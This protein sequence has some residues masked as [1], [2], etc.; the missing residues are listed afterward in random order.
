MRRTFLLSVDAIRH[1]PAGTSRCNAHRLF[2]TE[3]IDDSPKRPRVLA[4]ESSTNNDDGPFYSKYYKLGQSEVESY[5]KRHDLKYRKTGRHLVVQECP[6]CHPTK[7]AP[8]NMYKLYILASTGVYKCHRCQA[9]GSWF[10]LRKEIGGAFDDFQ[11]LMEMGEFSDSGPEVDLDP[12]KP[13]PPRTSLKEYHNN[14]H[15]KHNDML[16]FIKEQR[17]LTA[18]VLAAYSVGLAHNTFRDE[19]SGEYCQEQCYMFPMFSSRRKL[20]RYKVRAVHKKRFM[21]LE[22]KG[23]DWGLFGFD[24]L[25][26]GTKEVVLTE[27]EFDAMAVYQ[28]TGRPALSLPNG[29]SSLPVSV[30]QALER[31]KTIYLWMDDDIPGQDGAKQFA[32]KLG[33]NRCRVVLTDGRAKDAN[34]ALLK[35]LDLEAMVA[36]AGP[37]PHEGVA[38][39]KD[40]KNEVYNEVMYPNQLKGM[41]S[42]LLPRLT[43]VLSGHRRGELTIYSGHT[44]TG[45]TTLLSQLSLDYCIQ[46]VPTLWGS[47]EIR[48][49]RLARLLLEQLYSSQTKQ[50]VSTLQDNFAEW[51]ERFEELPMYFM[52][53]HGS[54]PIERVIDAMEYGNYVH[55]VSHVLLDNL[56]FMT[57][58]QARNSFDRF[59]VMDGAIQKLRQYS[60]ENNVH[61]SLVVHPRK[62]NDG[63]AI[64]TSS[65]FGSAKATQEADNVIIL[66]R[67]RGGGRA[68]EVRKNRFDGELGTLQLAFDKK[69]KLFKEKNPRNIERQSTGPV[70]DLNIDPSMSMIAEQFYSGSVVPQL[71]TQAKTQFHAVVPE[72]MA[73]DA[74][75]Q[76]RRK[77]FDDGND[78]QSAD[79]LLT[80]SGVD[81]DDY[82]GYHSSLPLMAEQYLKKRPPLRETLRSRL[83]RASTT[84]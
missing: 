78:T 63:D 49:V 12:K 6:F 73:P 83:A 68:L 79:D 16:K 3:A 43:D 15:V 62:E 37:V 46:G 22:P 2:C 21:K 27:G 18:E 70:N 10:Q 1:L 31:F 26:I 30:V 80:D 56:Q 75:K 82:E 14:L 59:E 71:G 11:P 69:L 17:G 77:T 84:Q 38:T 29:A 28:A 23:G 5:L 25:P 35:G 44:G 61:V 51:A 67:T 4:R 54:S 47:F 19:E 42:N 76:D 65:V 8:S 7:G 55:D 81:Y 33:R 52:R 20:M 64:Q 9:S 57:S 66:Q 50:P 24:T 36:N 40:L 74:S 45:K 39:F 13:C 58:G 53:Y 41:Q 32:K 72:R 60:S 48:N 34:D